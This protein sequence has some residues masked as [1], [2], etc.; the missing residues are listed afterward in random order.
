MRVA[1]MVAGLVLHIGLVAL[2]VRILFIIGTMKLTD[3]LI[4]LII[5]PMV[6][7]VRLEI[8]VALESI[9]LLLAY[10]GA[11]VTIA[12]I[13]LLVILLTLLMVE[14]V[15][16]LMVGEL[17]ILMLIINLDVTMVVITPLLLLLIVG[18]VK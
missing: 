6:V 15:L 17:T 10:L 5:V 4:G 2:I 13:V 16:A 8:Q 9:V 1:L 3:T 14:L 12:I 18:L 11:L 7:V